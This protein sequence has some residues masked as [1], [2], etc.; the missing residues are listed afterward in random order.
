MWAGLVAAGSSWA[1]GIEGQVGLSLDGKP[2]RAGEAVDAVVYFRPTVPVTTVAAKDPVE[3]RME[4]KTF[5]P[6]ALPVTVGSTVRFQ[7]FDPKAIP[8]TKLAAG[9]TVEFTV[10]M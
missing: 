4:R 9:D 6:R 1:A 5:L 8:P 7:N 2:L 10:A 3:M